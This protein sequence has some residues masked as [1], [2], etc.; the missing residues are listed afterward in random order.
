MEKKCMTTL[1]FLGIDDLFHSM[2]DLFSIKAKEVDYTRSIFSEHFKE[3]K[4]I[5]GDSV[6]Y[7]N[8]FK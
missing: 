5:V 1:S 2:A 4:R 3:R 6:D 7:D 8:Y